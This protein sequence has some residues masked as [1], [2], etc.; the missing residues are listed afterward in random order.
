MN[1]TLFMDSL[2]SK[3]IMQQLNEQALFSQ[4]KERSRKQ[5]NSISINLNELNRN[6]RISSLAATSSKGKKMSVDSPSSK[7]FQFDKD[8]IEINKNFIIPLPQVSI[9]QLTKMKNP[10]LIRQ[11]KTASYDYIEADKQKY[12]ET[13]KY[14]SQQKLQVAQKPQRYGSIRLR[15]RQSYQASPQSRRNAGQNNQRS[16]MTPIKNSIFSGGF[17]ENLNKFKTPQKQQLHITSSP[18]NKCDENLNNNTQN[19]QNDINK[20]DTLQFKVD[21]NNFKRDSVFK[22][23]SLNKSCINLLRNESQ[24]ILNRTSFQKN[25][26]KERGSIFQSIFNQQNM[27]LSE[28]KDNNNKEQLQQ[29]VEEQDT[30]ASIKNQS[31]NSKQI[32]DF[33]RS[34]LGSTRRSSNITNFNEDEDKVNYSLNNRFSFLQSIPYNKLVFDKLSKDSEKYKKEV[35]KSLQED[36]LITSKVD[37]VSEK[38]QGEDNSQGIKFN[39]QNGFKQ[40][41]FKNFKSNSIERLQTF[42]SFAFNS[43]DKSENKYILCALNELLDDIKKQGSMQIIDLWSAK[44]LKSCIERTNMGNEKFVVQQF[45]HYKAKFDNQK[46]K[47]EMKQSQLLSLQKEKELK[48]EILRQEQ[49][50]KQINQDIKNGENSFSLE[51]DNTQYNY[52]QQMLMNSGQYNLKYKRALNNIIEEI[53]DMKQENIEDIKNQKLLCKTLKTFSKELE[54]K[55]KLNK[56]SKK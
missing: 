20:N 51:D 18:Y 26:L 28:A 7:K 22:R 56:I 53:K 19:Q 17:N 16:S 41:A 12:N 33:I 38:K 6:S 3:S 30:A 10:S 42:F 48:D 24:E 25:G 35:I 13:L 21:Q 54:I 2:H 5:N 11:G 50:K 44:S 46:K 34:R 52:N 23:S 15:Q 27:E 36:K 14:L 8:K 9:N 31:H 49:T 45:L 4:F 29:S 37:K 39:E 55:Y 43:I 47:E 40:F 32:N 1:S